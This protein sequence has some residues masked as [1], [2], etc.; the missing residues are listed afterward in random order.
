METPMT[1]QLAQRTRRMNPSLVRGILKLAD[2]PG[3]IS[4]AGGL[5][6]PSTFPIE[7]LREATERVWRD[8][9][10]HALQYTASEGHGPL[11]EWLAESLCAQGL[12]VTADQ[13]L[14][15]TGSQQGLDLVAKLLLDAGSTVAVESPTF[16]GALQAFAMAEPQV[17]EWACDDEGPRPDAL[18]ALRGARLAYVQPTFHNPTGRCLSAARRQ[19]MVAAAQQQGVPLLEDNPYGDLWFDAPPPP[20]LASLW[21]EGVVYLGSFSKVLAPGLRLGYLVAPPALYPKL[22]QAKQAADLHTATFNQRLVWALIEQGGMPA[23]LQALRGFYRAQR[24]AMLHALHTHLPGGCERP[25]GRAVPD[26]P[27]EGGKKT[28]GG[29]ALSCEWQSPSGGLFVWLRL[30]EGADALALLPQALAAG[31]AYVPGA[32]FYAG[33]PDA[34]RVRLSFA[35]ATPEQIDAGI[36]LLATLLKAPR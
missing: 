25:Q 20:P 11:R 4:L 10:Q 27:P 36:R 30:P 33:E 2:R 9:P 5:P 35:T 31:V 18:M 26:P 21:P 14:I 24:D 29:P 13:V 12:R 3:V 22:L 16:L 28:W 1:W 34:R 23:H 8:Q 6:A 32:A 19:A 7:A 17:A 15:T